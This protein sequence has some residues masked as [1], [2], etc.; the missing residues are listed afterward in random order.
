VTNYLLEAGLRWCCN[1]GAMRARSIGFLLSVL[2]LSA[3]ASHP[4]PASSLRALPAVAA[5]PTHPSAPAGQPDRQLLRA[6]AETR[7]FRNGAP[8]AA[9]PTADGKA[10]LFLRSGPRDTK[11]SLFELDLGSGATRE[12][13][14]LAAIHSGEEA[15]SQAERARRERMRISAKGIT[16]F[17][18]SA[19]SSRVL[20]DVAGKLFVVTRASGAV[21]PIAERVLDPRWSPDG[22]RIAFVRDHDLVTVDAEG[23]DV[24]QLTRG[25]TAAK[26]HGVAEFIAQEEFHRSRGFWWA[27]DGA[28]LLFEEADCASVEELVIVDPAFPE[29]APDRAR[30]P[31]AGRTNCDLRFG[32]VNARGG[33]TTWLDWDAKRY[34]YVATV[35]WTKG[36][37]PTLFALDRRQRAAALIAADPVRGKTTALLEEQDA[38][39]LNVD[40]SAPKWLSDGSGFLWSSERDGR[41]RLELRDAKGALVRPLT[42]ASLGYRSVLDVDTTRKVAFVSASDDPTSSSIWSVPLEG[43][44]PQPLARAATGTFGEGHDVFVASEAS[45][46]RMPHAQARTVDGGRHWDLPS[47]AETPAPLPKVEMVELAPDRTRVAIV[48]PRSFDRQRQYAVI[49]SAY[50]GPGALTVVSNVATYIRAQWMADTADA[51]VV[52]IDARGTPFRGREWERALVG[53]MAEVPLEGHVEALQRL[54][55][56]FS[57]MDMSRVGIFGW[58]FGGYLAAFGVLA[59]PDVYK[60]GVAGAAPADW[61]DYDTAYTERYLGHPSTETAA[62]DA[63]SLLVRARMP[64]PD[65][66]LLV[67][68]GT[69]DDNVYFANSLRLTDALT[70]AGRP[71]EFVPLLGITHQLAEPTVA[72]ATWL[73]IATFLRDHLSVMSPKV[74]AP[75]RP[76]R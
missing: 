47:V 9:M 35:T 3:C 1:A 19:D 23:K 32:L 41:W 63:A 38:A 16:S 45:L 27:P 21:K 15:L 11:Q 56:R 58:S 25:G 50:G 76:I 66:P 2:V 65:R 5:P 22:K 6:L 68:H 28:R 8:Q 73:R 20:F 75:I 69:A 4:R 33:P 59:R 17:D 72:E 57:E 14:P 60:V 40:A 46:D 53:K 12:L 70:R 37:P 7:N 71:Y 29:R 39:W 61:R 54:A 26:S 49:D 34:P 24:V 62:Y 13:V 74:V 31:R 48:R 64:G 44:A 42:E 55:G 36:G 30:Y 52:A 18:I 43:G 51:I 10:V 67:V